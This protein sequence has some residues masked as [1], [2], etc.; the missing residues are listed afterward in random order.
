[1]VR[2]HDRSHLDKPSHEGKKSDSVT[3]AMVDCYQISFGEPGFQYAMMVYCDLNEYLM[4]LQILKGAI[5]C[6]YV[7]WLLYVAKNM[8]CYIPGIKG[9]ESM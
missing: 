4:Q 1:M 5:L 3:T 9:E 2:S 8:Q 6:T 7:A